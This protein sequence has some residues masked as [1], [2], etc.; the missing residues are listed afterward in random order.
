MEAEP[1]I[2]S[3]AGALASRAFNYLANFAPD[4]M[5]LRFNTSKIAHTNGDEA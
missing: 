4:H 3:R 2:I 1:A 5:M